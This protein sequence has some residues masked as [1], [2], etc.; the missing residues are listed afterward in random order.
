MGTAALADLTESAKPNR[1]ERAAKTVDAALRGGILVGAIAAIAWLMASAVG[2]IIYFALIVVTVLALIYTAM[3]SDKA[4]LSIWLFIGVAWA[5]VLAER[6]LVKD[7]GG[8]IVA[9]A[10]YLGIVFG[11]RSAGLAKKSYPFLLYPLISVAICIGADTSIADPWGV[12]WLWVAAVLG[13]VVGVR[14]LLN[15][16]PRD[17]KP[18]KNAEPAAF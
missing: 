9:G 1:R 15:P 10:A 3:R 2:A 5:L 13:P 7:H 4:K 17:H 6:W 12:S 8:L 11:A 14:T 16:S 18:E